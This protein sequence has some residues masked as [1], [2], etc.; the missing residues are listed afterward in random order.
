METIGQH[1]SRIRNTFN[2]TSSDTIVTNR[3][4]Y[5]L[6]KKNRDFVVKRDR[7]QKIIQQDNLFQTINIQELQEVD[8]VEACG[9][10]TDCKIKRTKY[11]LPK[12]I[13]ND[14]G[15]IIRWVGALDGI[16]EIKYINSNAFQRKVRKP[17][18]KYNNETY[19]WFKDGYLYFP[20]TEWDAVRIEGF[21]DED[22]VNDCDDAVC[23]NRNQEIFRIPDYLVTAMDQLI[24]QELSVHVQLPY[25]ETQNDNT[26]IK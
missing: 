9:I 10:Q 5:S 4:I 6:M 11:K 3:Y 22:V 24:F 13:E 18:F 21:F 23:K 25:D 7:I 15:V 16:K 12:L 8:T 14:Y 17:T 2:L 1:I 20:N 26:N 19:Y